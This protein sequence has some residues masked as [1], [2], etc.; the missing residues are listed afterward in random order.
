MK[1]HIKNLP[2][3]FITKITSIIFIIIIVFT[4][5]SCGK[6]ETIKNPIAIGYKNGIAYIINDVGDELSLEKYDKVADYF[7]AY[8]GVKIDNKWGFIKNTGEEITDI[9]YDRVCKMSENKAV[10]VED[11]KTL[12]IDNNGK[13]LYTFSN[14]ITSY[15]YF[16]ENKLIIE[17]DG[18]LGYLE[19][20]YSTSSFKILI[21]P[22]YNYADMFHEGFAAVGMFKD[23]KMKYS[24]LKEDGNLMFSE[25]NYDEA[26]QFND[27]YARVGTL[28]ST[29]K[30]KYLSNTLSE[31]GN[32]IYLTKQNSTQ[33][34]EYDYA[35][36][37]SNGIAFVANYKRYSQGDTEDTLYYRWYTI[38]D[39]LGN[40]NYG[41]ILANSTIM[42]EVPKNFFPHSPIFV[43]D[44]LVFQN[45][46]R[47]SNVWNFY[48][49]T[50]Y[51]QLNE[52]DEYFSIYDFDEIDFN[53]NQEQTV[54]KNVMKENHWTFELSKSLLSAPYEANNFKYNEIT[55]SFIASVKISNDKMGIIKIVSTLMPEEKGNSLDTHQFKIEYIITPTYD[56]IIY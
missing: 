15:S 5:T 11:G 25:F 27:G 39:T 33:V 29:M 18:L 24:Y 53:I 26:S 40:F 10:V 31:E 42:K 3:K 19:Y 14:G 35:T 36:D 55:D 13:T 54:V 2:S 46:Y 8:I 51:K 34:I 52:N 48:R 4:I 12:I 6:N 22:T 32:P 30:Y 56:N 21:E 41:D 16:N 9:K 7:D 23:N 38:V 20:N 43:D 37:F 49:Y 17:K 47:S 44:V 28:I 50:I 45:G 1:S